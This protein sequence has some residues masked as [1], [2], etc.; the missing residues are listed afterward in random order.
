MSRCAAAQRRYPG[1]FPRVGRGSAPCAAYDL[2]RATISF[3]ITRSGSK[4]AIDHL[5]IRGIER[6]A[7][8]DALQGKSVLQALRDQVSNADSSLM[9]FISRKPS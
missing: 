2:M 1:A 8:F 5:I 6:I 3:C 4:D 9:H 7:E